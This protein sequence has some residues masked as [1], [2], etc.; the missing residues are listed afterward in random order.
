[1][2]TTSALLSLPLMATAACGSVCTTELVPGIRVLLDDDWPNVT[3][4]AT[5]GSF[6]ETANVTQG[7]SA[8]DLVYERPGSYR[9]E[10]TASGY[11]TWTM[12]NVRVEDDAC[13]VQTVELT[14]RLVPDGG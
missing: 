13:H 4:T 2:R 5:E 8:V 3:V 10:V 9:I 14:P 12:S 6:S 11:A 7:A 1:M